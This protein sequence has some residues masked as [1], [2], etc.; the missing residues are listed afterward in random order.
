M[1]DSQ[2]ILI[3]HAQQ[4]WRDRDVARSPLDALEAVSRAAVDNADCAGLAPCIDTV[5]TIP[6]LATQVPDLAGLMPAHPGSALCQRLGLQAQTFS[7][8][9]GG[10]TP[11]LMVNFFADR[12]VAG[13]SRAVL[14]T[15][16]ELFATLFAALSSGQDI[17]H[18]QQ[19]GEQ[20]A[21]QLG[22]PKEPCTE[23]ERAHGMFEP[24]NTYPLFESALCHARGWDR[25]T[26]L[27]RLGQLVSGM[28]AVAAQ[29]PHAWRGDFLTPEQVLDTGGGNRMIT[30]PYTKVMNAVLAV[31][32]AA[33]V[34]MTTV[35]EARRLG[36]DPARWVYLRGGAEGNDIWNVSERPTLH[37]SLALA[38]SADAA[39][40]MAG[41]SLAALDRFDLYSCFP[42]AVQVA[43]DAIGL[44]ADDPRGVTVTGGLTLFGGPGNNY[45][46][47]AIA[48]M[49]GQLQA[50]NGR[51]GMVTANGN[52]LTK[53]AVGIYSLDPGATPWPLARPDLQTTLDAAP[54]LQ[55]DANAS[56]TGSIDACAVVFG[57]EGPNRGIVLGR[58]GDGRRFIANTP[59][60]DAAAL[61]SL[62]ASDPVGEQG[63]VTPGDK[64]NCFEF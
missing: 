16:G 57:K 32:M 23:L 7:T 49:V 59:Q 10:N 12:L 9:V 3:A 5:A 28:S 8:D 64:V 42:S 1:F 29:N 25:A 13:T 34:I 37:R 30:W 31:D 22:S 21:I 15:G 18:W 35:G 39:L 61:E 17:S 58:M 51:H 56:G 38:A 41:L 43:C 19:R 52:Y 20:P 2:P 24:I 63:R 55:V 27:Q 44:A 14:L 4:T 48:E 11:Q 60:G 47:H 45:S 36:I 62:L 33:A 53:H 40:R 46:L 6:F 54:R 26:H 50:G